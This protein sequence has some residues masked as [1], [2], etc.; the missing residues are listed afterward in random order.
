MKELIAN[1]IWS[2]INYSKPNKWKLIKESKNKAKGANPHLE[3]LDFSFAESDELVPMSIRVQLKKAISNP[4]IQKDS[5]HTIGVFREAVAD[6]MSTVYGV[7]VNPD[8]EVTHCIGVKQA[9]ALLP[10]CFVNPNE[11]VMTTLPG[12]E[13]L[14]LHAQYLGAKIIN[15]PL[16]ASNNF[17]PNL[18]LLSP[19]VLAETKLF[20]IN[21]PNN[22]TG[23]TANTA[24]FD[25]LIGLARRYNFLIIHDAVYGRL[26]YNDSPLSILS[27]PFGKEVAIELHSLTK[28]FN[29]SGWRMGFAVGSAEAVKAFSIVRDSSFSGK[30]KSL[31]FVSAQALLDHSLQK[32][33][34][35]YWE[36]RMV[37]MTTALQQAG[38]AARMPEGS[39]CLYVPA[40]V[41]ALS[42]QVKF[43]SAQ[44]ASEFILHKSLLS[45]VPYDEAG[46]YLRF[47]ATFTSNAET[48]DNRIFAETATRLKKLNLEW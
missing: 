3:L 31:Q 45:T 26:V 5:S 34:C 14:G 8:M 37:K 9:L 13:T 47:C 46:S 27:R 40:P 24:F 4:M 32:N 22:P 21:Y 12:Y 41:G 23:A 1:R 42:G 11:K 15:L 7:A 43:S 36:R 33:I 19:D 35:K 28:G 38:F 6:Y 30:F 44:E 18:S 17:L 16:L 39:L 20:Y 10:L 29:M 25:Q 2:E 48:E